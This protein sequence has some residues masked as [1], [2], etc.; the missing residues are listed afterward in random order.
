MGDVISVLSS[1]VRG[2]DDVSCSSVPAGQSCARLAPLL[3]YLKEAGFCDER[4]RRVQDILI[5]ECFRD[6]D[7]TISRMGGE[8]FDLTISC[9]M[10]AGGL[11]KML[12]GAWSVSASSVELLIG[13]RY[14]CDDDVIVESLTFTDRVVTA[15]VSAHEFSKVNEDIRL[16]LESV[17]DYM[18]E[19]QHRHLMVLWEQSCRWSH[20]SC[21]AAVSVFARLSDGFSIP[22]GDPHGKNRM[23][24]ARQLIR[25]VIVKRV[26][27]WQVANTLERV[28]EM[29]GVYS[30]LVRDAGCPDTT[31]CQLLN[32][33][34]YLSG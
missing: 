20:F 14:L 26:E 29:M 30:R 23:K 16:E 13:S 8:D 27:G 12:A 7:I 9:Y 33:A 32:T 11:K 22:K 15:V 24:N 5:K 18:D 17:R 34:R 1:L 21:E 28:K 19:H 25:S 3:G 31:V 4:L 2:E 6:V 10:T